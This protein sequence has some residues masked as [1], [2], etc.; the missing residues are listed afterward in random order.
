MKRIIGALALALVSFG[1][2]TVARPPHLARPAPAVAA[3][4]AGAR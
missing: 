3:S 2:L 4:A 1:S